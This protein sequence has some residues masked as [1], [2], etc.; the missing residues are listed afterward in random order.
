[1]AS[2]IESQR[3]YAV[4]GTDGS[5]KTSLSEMLIFDAGAI[6]RLGAIQE[7]TTVLD[8]E[9]EE[10]QRQG[11]I[12]PGVATYEWKGNRHFLLDVPGG[13]NF[14]GDVE[15]L[16]K[17]TN[18]VIFI[19]D[20]VD[21]VRP[22]TK[23]I[24]RFM[25]RNHLPTLIAINKMDRDNANF[26][27]TFESL[28]SL[29]IKPVALQVPILEN[30]EF[31][32]YVD[33]LSDKAYAFDGA[34]VKEIPTPDFMAD[35]IEHFRSMSIENVAE[36][37]DAMLEKYLEGEEISAEELQAAIHA[38]VLKGIIT[39]VLTC[40]SLK[41]KGG[42]QILDAVQAYLP[43]PFDHP[44]VKDDQGGKH[45]I[46]AGGPL[47]CFVFKSIAEPASGQLYS[48]MR[49]LSGT[50][51]SDMVLINQ[52]TGAEERIGNLLYVLGKS[53][54]P[55][56][57]PVGPGAVVAVPRLKTTRAGD[58]L[59]DGSDPFKLA[60]A[61]LPPQLITFAVAAKNKNEEDKVYSALQKL[62][63]DD[64]MLKLDHDDE[65]G[66]ILLSGMGQLHVKLAVER[67]KRRFKLDIL[68]KTPKIPYRET[69]RGTAKAQG[70]HKKQSGGHGQYGDCWI[71]L[72]GMPRGS[73]CSFE[74]QITG[75][76]IPRQYIP[77]VD[78]G[79]Q[80]AAMH[81]RIAGYPVVDFKVSLYDGS[82]HTVDSSE[83]AFKMAGRLA[84]QNAA[85]QL[86]PVLLEPIAM[87]TV[88]VPDESMGD[89]IG[90]LS[91]R[92]GRVLGSDSTGGI[93]EIK[94]QVPMSE[95]LRYA[96]DLRSMTGGQGSFTMGFDHYAEAPEA[97]V[98]KVIEE[99]QKAES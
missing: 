59:C 27:A 60:V 41:D 51:A 57:T 62:Q 77:A 84:F 26:Q 86:E 70:R 80:E 89:V 9:P 38:G 18:G 90:D 15:Y 54:K 67:A 82:Y 37:D 6:T 71:E 93:T 39:P 10:I 69:L 42:H 16:L 76:V 21:R 99:H 55:C 1:M 95:I 96:S 48:I 98:E 19:I 24:W 58:T 32:G 63:E 87:L 35:E 52:R 81:G 25:R 36:T 94:A 45:K 65:T 34:D 22:L 3:T 73:G 2:P 66:D 4:V 30:G 83:M 33:T 85:E 20:A 31:T 72:T 7:G 53:F 68:L 12:Q 79:I 75:G 23:M 56:K 14:A 17:G 74:D 91:A 40:S 78:K 61:A 97:V 28:S 11:S 50:L 49:V 47:S 64:V 8:Y 43:S 5:G 29:G 44:T 88:S 13:S 92:R 46:A